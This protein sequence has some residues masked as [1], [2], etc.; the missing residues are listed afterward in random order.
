L[1][2]I[3]GLTFQEIETRVKERVKKTIKRIEKEINE[4]QGIDVNSKK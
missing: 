3:E 1:A 4:I 2:I